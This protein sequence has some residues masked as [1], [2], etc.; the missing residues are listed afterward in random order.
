MA[1]TAAEIEAEIEIVSTA[2]TNILLTGQK[3]E[4]GSGPSKRIFEAANINNLTKYRNSLNIQLKGINGTSG[5]Q[6]GY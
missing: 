3:Y 6:L 2:I 5:M 1:K 4:V